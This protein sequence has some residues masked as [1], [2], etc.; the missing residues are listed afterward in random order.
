MSPLMILV[1]PLL[2]H[3][4]A[5]KLKKERENLNRML[6]DHKNSLYPGYDNGLKKLGCTL[7]TG[8]T[9]RN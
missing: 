6:E 3:G 7:H 4:E 9:N 5:T 2:M 1:G 8:H